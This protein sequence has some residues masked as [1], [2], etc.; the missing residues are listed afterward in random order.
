MVTDA[1]E[2]GHL[3]G[4]MPP[5]LEREQQPTV[6]V[7]L[8]PPGRAHV[9]RGDGQHDPVERGGIGRPSA[10]S[11]R[12]RGRARRRLLP[13]APGPPPRC[14]RPRRSAVTSPVSPTR[15]AIS[16]ALKP[17]PGPDLQHSLAGLEV[18]HLQH[19]RH[20]LGLRRRADGPPSMRLRPDGPVAVDL[21]QG[22]VRQEQVSWHGA[23]RREDGRAGDG[24]PRAPASRR[25]PAGAVRHSAARSSR[26]MQLRLA[27]DRLS[28]TPRTGR[29]LA[30]MAT[31]PY[32]PGASGDVLLE[33]VPAFGPGVEQDSPREPLRVAD[34][35]CHRS[36]Q[37]PPMGPDR[38]LGE[39]TVQPRP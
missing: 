23:E 2:G 7:E 37:A 20:D 10:P 4:Q 19:D 12:T 36:G 17:V 35:L 6:R 25:D 24:A 11:P 5:I 22:D 28:C 34:H 32:A 33:C 21:G 8:L 27:Y 15:W 31:S 16:A 1:L 29:D 26:G 9:R 39:R 3:L 14:R 38:P 18:E 13:G 30:R